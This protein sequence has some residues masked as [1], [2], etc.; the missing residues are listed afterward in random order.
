[1]LSISTP[2]SSTMWSTKADTTKSR[3]ADRNEGSKSLSLIQS[4]ASSS[5]TYLSSPQ[6]FSIA[7]KFTPC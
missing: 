2:L 7:S 6:I 3:Q 1:M 4:R 5:V